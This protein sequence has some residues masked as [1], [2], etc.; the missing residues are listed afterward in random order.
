MELIWSLFWVKFL[1]LFD[2][3]RKIGQEYSLSDIHVSRS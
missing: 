1:T 2:A 3:I